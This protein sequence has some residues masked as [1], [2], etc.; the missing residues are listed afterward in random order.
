VIASE[1]WRLRNQIDYL[2][3][4][5]LVWKEY[6][7]PSESWDH[8]HCAFCWAKFMEGDY[9]DV[10]HMGYATEDDYDWVCKRCFDDFKEMFGWTARDG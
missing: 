8:D 9:P 2:R 3:N 6:H 5:A 10:L 4:A 7:T 1:D